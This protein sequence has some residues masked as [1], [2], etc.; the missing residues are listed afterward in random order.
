MFQV[1]GR[2]RTEHISRAHILG[3]L[4]TTGF[5]S[6]KSNQGLNCFKSANL[7]AVC[8]VVLGLAIPEVSFVPKSLWLFSL[9]G[10]HTPSHVVQ[11]NC[12]SSA[13]GAV[14]L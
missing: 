1:L 3:P 8:L 7:G 11:S 9:A 13:F 4:L 12:E 6:R 2:Q 14:V 10:S 5:Y